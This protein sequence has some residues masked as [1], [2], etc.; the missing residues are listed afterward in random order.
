MLFRSDEQL[1]YTPEQVTRNR[2]PLER[3]TSFGATW[4]LRYGPHNRFR[5]F[6]EVD[7]SEQTVTI[8]AI[9]VKEGHRLVIGGEEFEL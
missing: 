2:K 6:Y 5:V 1:S 9:G 3:P 8:L 4:K 7:A